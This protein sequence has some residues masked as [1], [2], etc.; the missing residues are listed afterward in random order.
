MIVQYLHT[1]AQ[2][3]GR[4]GNR[5]CLYMTQ[6]Y[7]KQSSVLFLFLKENLSCPTEYSPERI[8]TAVALKVVLKLQHY[9]I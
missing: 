4:P 1:S 8:Y 3:Q 6:I 7:G 2:P 9:A 5:R